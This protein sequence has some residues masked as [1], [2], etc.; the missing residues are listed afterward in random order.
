MAEEAINVTDVICK[1]NNITG[2]LYGKSASHE[3]VQPDVSTIA[4]EFVAFCIKAIQNYRFVDG[5]VLLLRSHSPCRFRV[6][7]F[8]PFGL[9]FAASRRSCRRQY[10][11]LEIWF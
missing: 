8:Y 11:V 2:T 1:C 6:F 10:F 9:V 3:N 5:T 7:S 4:F